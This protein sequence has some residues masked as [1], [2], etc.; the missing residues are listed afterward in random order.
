[1][2][3]EEW[4]KGHEQDPD[5]G[6]VTCLAEQDSS[7]PATDKKYCLSRFV[8]WQEIQFC[9]TFFGIKGLKVVDVSDFRR[10]FKEYSVF[11]LQRCFKVRHEMN[12]TRNI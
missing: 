4:D 7:M 10:L 12:S 8:L 5:F 2:K 9:N 11:D 1:M 6:E 3:S